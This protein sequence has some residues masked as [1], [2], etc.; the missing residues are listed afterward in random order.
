[1][2]L[3]FRVRNFPLGNSME[4]GMEPNCILGFII[5]MDEIRMMEERKR[6][7]FFSMQGLGFRFL[8]Q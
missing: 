1:M 4:T 7:L 3:G 8:R 5:G 6:K 2:G